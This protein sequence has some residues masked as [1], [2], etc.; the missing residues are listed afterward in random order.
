MARPKSS[1]SKG[2]A[3]VTSKYH[4][5][6][7]VIDGITFHS[8]KEGDR[9]IQ[10][11]LLKNAGLISG[12]ELQKSF[13]LQPTFKKNG[14]TYRKIVYIADFCYFD[15]HL[16]KYIVEDVKGFRTKEYALKKKMF[17]YVYKDL[18]LMEV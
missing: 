17:E 5:K 9:Y 3:K 10:L 15:N 12:L 14:K 18:E 11:K 2:M 16:N 4:S 8:Q 6:K 13:E 7:V 1:L